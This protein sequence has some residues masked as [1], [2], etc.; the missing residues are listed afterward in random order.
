[1]LSNEGPAMLATGAGPRLP[2]S[3]WLLKARP[4]RTVCRNG[5]LARL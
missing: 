3:C 1:M 2:V 4:G 5:Q